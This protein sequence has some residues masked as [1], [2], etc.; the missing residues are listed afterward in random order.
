MLGP[1]QNRETAEFHLLGLHLE[2]LFRFVAERQAGKLLAIIFLVV[3]LTRPGFERTFT[4]SA[5]V[6]LSAQALTSLIS[7]KRTNTME[8]LILS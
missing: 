2:Q 7:T 1:N 8:Y 5:V 6:P 4:V 3:G